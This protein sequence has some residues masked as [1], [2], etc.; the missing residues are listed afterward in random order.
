MTTAVR[1]SVHGIQLRP[2]RTITPKVVAQAR[3]AEG[4]DEVVKS[5]QRVI[6]QHRA[7]LEALKDR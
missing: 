5:A 6:K 4:R 3:T 7:V 2:R 1:Q